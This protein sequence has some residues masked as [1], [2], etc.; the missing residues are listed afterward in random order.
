MTT[1]TQETSAVVQ[2]WGLAAKAGFQAI[3][4][5]LL[6]NQAALELDNT[7]LVVLI[8]LTMHWWYEDTLPFPRTATIAKRMGCGVRTVQRSFSKM[9]KLGL[10]EKKKGTKVFHVKSAGTDSE[11]II[12]FEASYYDPSG[13][14]DKLQELAKKDKDFMV[15]NPEYKENSE[16]ILK[17][18]TPRKDAKPNENIP[19]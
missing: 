12:D 8:N 2:K 4:D 19:F 10:V 1:N 18:E 7:D 11:E 17:T 16:I 9:Q 3:P 15:R 13:L 5:V 6:K 14:V